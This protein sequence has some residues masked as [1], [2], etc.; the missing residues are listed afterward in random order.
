MRS[1]FAL[2]YF[3]DHLQGCELLLS[4]QQKPHLFKGDSVRCFYKTINRA[5]NQ[6]N[7]KKQISD[8]WVRFMHPCKP[9]FRCV[10]DYDSTTAKYRSPKGFYV[11]IDFVTD[12]LCCNGMC[13]FEEFISNGQQV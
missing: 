8:T 3:R 6:P 12:Q 7:I 5:L 1:F 9:E 4:V 13:H 2:Q 10:L 11:I